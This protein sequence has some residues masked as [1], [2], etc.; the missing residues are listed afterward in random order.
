MA[1]AIVHHF[2]SGTQEQYENTVKAVHPDGGNAPPAG[3]IFHFAGPTED[4]GWIVVGV[5][6][7]KASWERFRDET[8]A[9]HLQSADDALPGPP[10]ELA[11]EVQVQQ[12]Q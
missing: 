12:Q 4:G 5:H 2:P 3:Q 6:D 9:P 11:F 8:L 1:Y 10:E 7:E